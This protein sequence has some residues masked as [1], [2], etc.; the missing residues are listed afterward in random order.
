VEPNRIHRAD[1]K[2]A[3]SRG[4]N[5]VLRAKLEAL[6]ST[7]PDKAVLNIMTSA[8]E[9][10]SYILSGEFDACPGYRTVIKSLQIPNEAIGAVPVLREAQRLKNM[11]MQ[12][13]FEI[14]KPNAYDVD[15]AAIDPITKEMHCYAMKHSL[16][17]QI[18][19]NVRKAANQ[20]LGYKPAGVVVKRHVVVHL[21]D[22]TAAQYRARHMQGTKDVIA[23]NAG[24][25]DEFRII[26]PDGK[27]LKP[28]GDL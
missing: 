25:I 4:Q 20:L 12:L 6:G 16:M 3:N 15:L 28:N 5:P 13:Q 18:T 8:P 11:G 27:F 19:D 10:E 22:G 9:L 17:N 24:K 14:T 1:D 2:N 23:D 26:L 21:R 7:K